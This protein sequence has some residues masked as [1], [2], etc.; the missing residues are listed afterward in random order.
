MDNSYGKG[1]AIHHIG[2]EL[3]CVENRKGSEPH[4][5]DILVCLTIGKRYK[6]IGHDR[7]FSDVKYTVYNDI[8]FESSYRI[9]RFKTSHNVWSGEPRK[10][11]GDI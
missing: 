2:K 4:P 9:N 7:S 1:Q 11:T 6:I 3:V 8:G 10:K 5:K